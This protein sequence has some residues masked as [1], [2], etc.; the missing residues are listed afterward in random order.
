MACGLTTVPEPNY[1]AAEYQVPLVV[2]SDRGSAGGRKSQ[3]LRA[4][5]FKTALNDLLPTV[6]IFLGPSTSE[7]EGRLR[8]PTARSGRAARG[9][10]CH[11]KR[12]NESCTVRVSTKAILGS[13]RRGVLFSSFPVFWMFNTTTAQSSHPHLASRPDADTPSTCS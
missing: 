3:P 13:G 11:S 9:C 7:F 5:V 2:T 1:S 6:A 10:P 12:R 4:F 8:E